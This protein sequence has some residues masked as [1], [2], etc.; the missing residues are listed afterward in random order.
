MDTIPAPRLAVF[1]AAAEA[2]S[3]KQSRLPSAVRQRPEQSS[4]TTNSAYHLSSRAHLRYVA[5]REMV[6]FVEFP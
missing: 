1:L 6:D 3:P 2:V 5:E 4:S